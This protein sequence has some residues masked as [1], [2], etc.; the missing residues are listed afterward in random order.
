MERSKAADFGNLLCEKS[1]WKNYTLSIACPTHAS[2]HYTPSVGFSSSASTS[3]TSFVQSQTI[4][5]STT[6]GH[7]STNVFDQ[8]ISAS[9]NGFYPWQSLKRTLR[10]EFI[11]PKL[12]A[13]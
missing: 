1:L 13:I 2:M 4:T 8:N 6:S 12:S 7:G 5:F 11:N 9:S 10:F 3:T